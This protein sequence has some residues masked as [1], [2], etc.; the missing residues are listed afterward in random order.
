MVVY[1]RPTVPRF[2]PGYLVVLSS[3]IVDEKVNP[4]G[5]NGA[6]RMG[7]LYPKAMSWLI[8]TGN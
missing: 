4:L 6:G 7:D 3:V 2:I 5:I 1:E 8:M